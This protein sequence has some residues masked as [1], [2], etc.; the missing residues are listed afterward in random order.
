VEYS[1]VGLTLCARGGGDE[2]WT[3]IPPTGDEVLPLPE[4]GVDIPVAELY[5]G[6]DLAED[7]AES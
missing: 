7:A 4:F 3:A 6:T 5:E 1:G 2:A